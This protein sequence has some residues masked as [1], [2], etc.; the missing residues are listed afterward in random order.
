[1]VC[2]SYTLYARRKYSGETY[3]GVAKTL[4]NYLHQGETTGTSSDSLQ[5]RQ[6]ENFSS[7]K[8]F[9][10]RGSEFFPLRA[11]PFGL[12]KHFYHSR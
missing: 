7:R 6:N 10:P 5:L 1:M 9:A 3:N 4:K 12:E 2:L 11:V 8:E